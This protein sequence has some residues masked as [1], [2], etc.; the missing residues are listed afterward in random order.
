MVKN[1]F[2]GSRH[3]GLARKNEK[4]D[5]NRKLRMP[6]S[7]DEKF[8]VVKKIYGGDMCEV[9]CDDNIIRIAVIRGKFSSGK[10]KR[11]NTIVI[12]TLLLIGLRSWA[13]SNPDKKDKCDV[14]EVYSP[15]EY[16]NLAALSSFPPLLIPSKISISNPHNDQFV[17]SSITPNTILTH[18]SPIHTNDIHNIDNIDILL[19]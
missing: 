8:A 11:Q 3:K 1:Q 15:I 10:G 12:S 6:Q 17:F 14:L 18:T 2:G 13:T 5:F 16:D 4:E 7:E 19:I 9:L